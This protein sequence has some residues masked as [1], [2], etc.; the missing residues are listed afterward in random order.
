MIDL[1]VIE[2]VTSSNREAV[3]VVISSDEVV[4]VV[5]TKSKQRDIGDDNVRGVVELRRRPCRT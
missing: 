3:I 5:V 2:V 1:H 4:E